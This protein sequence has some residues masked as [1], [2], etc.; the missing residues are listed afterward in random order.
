MFCSGKA[1]DANGKF[2]LQDGDQLFAQYLQ[3]RRF[4]GILPFVHDPTNDERT[5]SK[6]SFYG[7]RIRPNGKN[8]RQVH[9]QYFLSCVISIQSILRQ[10][11]D[12]N[13]AF[14][15]TKSHKG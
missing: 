3:D 9:N 12:V 8:V 11:D 13:E 15:H 10:N 4:W 7:I 14:T 2:P 1:E 6:H 5:I